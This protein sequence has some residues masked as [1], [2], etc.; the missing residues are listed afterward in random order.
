MLLVA[1]AGCIRPANENARRSGLWQATCAEQ[2]GDDGFVSIFDGKTLDGWHA[3]PKDSA[4]DWTVRAGAIIGHGSADRQSYLVWGENE[5]LTDFEIKLRYRL[6]GKGNTGIE[7]R[8]QPDLTGKRPFQGYHADLGHVGIGPN[9]LGAWDFHFAGRKEY[10]CPRGTRL[11]IDKD[12]KAHPVAIPGAIT[13]ADIRS[14]Q[15]NDVHIIVRGNQF[16]FF[17]NGKLSSEFI[18]NAENGRLDQGAIGLQLHNKDM[19][20]QFKDILL[21]VL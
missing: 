20:V 13:L 1:A 11:I 21:K 10:Q 3:V 8:A 4:P 9:I 16:K 18:D 17:I 14:H 19:V 6:P 12:G 2:S 15:W 7:T 5:H